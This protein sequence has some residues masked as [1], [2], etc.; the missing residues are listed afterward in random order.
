[1]RGFGPL[2]GALASVYGCHARAA[3]T[4][5]IVPMAPLRASQTALD[6]FARQNART[7]R[8]RVRGRW[9]AHRLSAVRRRTRRRRGASAAHDVRAALA[10]PDFYSVPI[11][12]WWYARRQLSWVF[13]AGDRAYKLS[14]PLVPAVLEQGT[15]ERRR[16]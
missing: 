10:R 6:Q 16:A 4:L 9:P 2:R 1:M 11:E 7:T 14:K 15:P 12:R 13:L 5:R 8:A 3:G